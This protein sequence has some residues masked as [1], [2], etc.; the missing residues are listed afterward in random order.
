LSTTGSC[1]QHANESYHMMSKTL[2]Q[3]SMRILQ[4]SCPKTYILVSIEE[5]EVENFPKHIIEGAWTQISDAVVKLLK[6]SDLIVLEMTLL[7][8][9]F[10]IGQERVLDV[11]MVEVP[12]QAANTLA[13]FLSGATSTSEVSA[14]TQTALLVFLG[15]PWTSQCEAACL[16]YRALAKR[17]VDRSS[18]EAFEKAL[19]SE[20]TLLCL[21]PSVRNVK[22]DNTS[23]S[24]VCDQAFINIITE[25]IAGSKCPCD[26]ADFVVEFWSKLFQLN[27]HH[28]I[29]LENP[30]V[31][32]VTLMR[33]TAT[34]AGAVLMKGVPA[35]LT[36]LVRA[37]MTYF[38]NVSIS[39]S[40]T[41]LVSSYFT[42]LLQFLEP[43]PKF[44]KAYTK[45]MDSVCDNIA[46][47]SYNGECNAFRK[48]LASTILQS[49]FHKFTH[50]GSLRNIVPVWVR[51]QPI[52]IP[53]KIGADDAALLDAMDLLD[54]LVEGL[55]LTTEHSVVHELIELFT[56]S[57]MGLAC[58]HVCA[59]LQERAVSTIVALC[60]AS[61]SH[62]LRTA[63]PTLSLELRNGSEDRRRFSA[64]KLLKQL[65]EAAGTE[66]CRFIRT[67]LPLVLSLMTD[68]LVECAQCATITF[69]S[70][71][72][73][74][75]LVQQLRLENQSIREDHKE[76][77]IDHLIFGKS[78]PPYNLPLEVCN[79]LREKNI[80]L[81]NYQKEGIAWLKFLQSVN[82]SG[83]LCDGK[84][85]GMF[86]F[87]HVLNKD[88]TFI[89]LFG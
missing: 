58:A 24:A 25:V 77:V 3:L 7:S 64:C 63:V 1:H 5:N 62:L 70:L 35:K 69:S 48:G 85:A 72:K 65:V 57:L 42:E 83:A 23:L 4:L 45:I 13:Y 73:L 46:Y 26:G 74:A 34:L 30:M 27:E 81:R 67:L 31:Y 53:Q 29:V 16:L 2:Q 40:R 68:K 38:N 76:S 82:L 78:L 32:P 41:S 43:N 60:V 89:R 17:L 19:D 54:V 20:M 8:W 55:T 12:I 18:L 15:S 51:L 88:L 22:L 79:A 47:R 14:V 44:Q 49:V 36:P 50:L 56:P 84:F 87:F 21:S 86:W 80:V 59:V 9:Y 52:A 28:E 37:L 71:V 33:V 66:F 39:T 75:P 6:N 11:E 61:P 10:D